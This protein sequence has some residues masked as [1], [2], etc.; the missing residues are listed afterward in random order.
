[1]KQDDDG[2]A[3][4]SFVMLH[5]SS[6]VLVLPRDRPSCAALPTDRSRPGQGRGCQCT[7]LQQAFS[8]TCRTADLSCAS[9]RCR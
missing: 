3:N 4:L 5:V 8:F 6:R 2:F 1:M 7:G 9:T